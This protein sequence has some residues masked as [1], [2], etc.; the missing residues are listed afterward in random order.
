MEAFEEKASFFT[1]H[2][3]GAVR[4]SATY[5]AN[6]GKLGRKKNSIE[7]AE[8]KSKIIQKSYPCLNVIIAFV[9]QRN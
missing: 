2:T 9:I 3:E 6:G 1:Q 8:Q 4:A 7:T 5:I